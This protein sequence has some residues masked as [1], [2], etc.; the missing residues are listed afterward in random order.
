[1]ESESLLQTL[2]EINKAGLYFVEPHHQRLK[3]IAEII[4]MS[5]NIGRIFSFGKGN[6]RLCHKKRLPVRSGSHLTKHLMKPANPFRFTGTLPASG[7]SWVTD[8]TFMDIN[9]Q[10]KS[11]IVNR[12]RKF[13][14]NK[15]LTFLIR[16]AK[17]APP[18]RA[19]PFVI[20]YVCV[21]AVLRTMRASFL[22]S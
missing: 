17:K 5:Y 11:L 9:I 20:R 6:V 8:F 19:E 1:M 10:C 16:F 2:D 13:L 3:R 22:R 4:F 15:I 7:L 18:Q 21:S 14:C 12:L